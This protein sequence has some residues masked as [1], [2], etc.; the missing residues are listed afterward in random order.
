[1]KN[2]YFAD[3]N[4]Y[5][6]YGILRCLEKSGLRIGVCWMLTPDD[7]RSDGR[8]I[9][10]LSRPDPWRTYDP[11][12]F[13]SLSQAVTKN[14]R[15]ISYI[16]G[17]G[18]LSNSSFFSLTVPYDQRERSRWLERFIVRSAD[19]DLLFFDP[20]NGIEVSS[21]ALGRSG[22]PKYLF[23]HE[24]QMA[25]N[26]GNALLIFQHFCR[27]KRDSFTMRL[28]RRI[29]ECLPQSNVASI[30]TANVVY[31]LAYREQ[32]ASRIDMGLR[33]LSQRWSGAVRI[34]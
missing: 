15:S 18:L 5:F 10:Y 29:E 16:E 14:A 17:S 34:R 21:T 23:W 19:S 22:S 25:W 28:S 3:V 7:G 2:Q 11:V 33:A 27:E 12:L 1:M 31:F 20:D 30:I 13:D 32:H 9:S 24:I 8:K 26:R 6:K 4:D